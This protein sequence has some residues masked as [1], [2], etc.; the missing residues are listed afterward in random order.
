MAACT[1]ALPPE[2]LCNA[3]RA[4]APFLGVI[5]LTYL[6]IQLCLLERP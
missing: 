6:D 1:M 4:S 2:S 5:G 3:W